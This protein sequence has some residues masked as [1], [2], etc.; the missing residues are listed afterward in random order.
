MTKKILF[1]EGKQKASIL[2]K[3]VMFTLVISTITDFYGYGSFNFTYISSVALAVLCIF[4][5]G[6]IKN[7]MPKFL[8]VYLV[9]Y[10]VVHYLSITSVTA[11]TIIPLG[12]IK[13]FLVYA[14]LFYEFDFTTF[15]KYFRL[16]AVVCIGYFLLQFF[17][18]HTTGVRLPSIIPGLPIIIGVDGAAFNMDALDSGSMN[19]SSF[20][21][22]KAKF[23]QFLLPL[24]CIELFGPVKRNWVFIGVIASCLVLSNSGNGLLGLLIIGGFYVA[25]NVT[26]GLSF[27]KIILLTV[28]GVS[29]VAFVGYYVTTDVGEEVMSRQDQL[30][31][32]GIGDA[33]SGQS[34]FIRIYSGYYVFAEYNSWE[35]LVGI[36][37]A[38]GIREKIHASKVSFLFNDENLYFNNALSVLIRTGYIGMILMIVLITSLWRKTD[39]CGRSLICLYIG[40]SFIASFYFTNFMAI[41]FILPYYL[42][43]KRLQKV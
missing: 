30:T 12:L 20:F 21:S 42:S 13:I 14:M 4:K 8:T 32:S 33:I 19:V 3:I 39:P 28:L 24:L 26:T 31:E 41:Y 38:N 6:G 15:Y 18:I 2:S 1:T 5:N 16:V 22:E 36:N 25:N 37:D 17:T 35:Q 40:L 27:K 23:A 34:G 43:K 7:I 11:T 10:A 29:A 9:W